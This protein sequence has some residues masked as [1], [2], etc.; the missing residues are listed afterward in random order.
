MVHLVFLNY[1][2]ID[3]FFYSYN[4]FK[5]KAS[6]KFPFSQIIMQKFSMAYQIE[7]KFSFPTL[8]NKIILFSLVGGMLLICS[9]I[10]KYIKEFLKNLEK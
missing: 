5:V 8:F 6:K 3:L 1:N 9:Y 2:L 4:N 7:N 10:L